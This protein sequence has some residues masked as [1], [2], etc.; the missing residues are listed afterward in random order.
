MK[1]ESFYATRDRFHVIHEVVY[2]DATN[3]ISDFAFQELQ[4]YQ[5]SCKYIEQSSPL[6]ISV[7]A[8]LTINRECLLITNDGESRVFLDIGFIGLAQSICRIMRYIIAV[9]EDA[10]PDSVDELVSQLV[11]CSEAVGIALVVEAA[12]L[13]GDYN[14]SMMF[15]NAIEG[16][17][18]LEPRWGRLFSTKSIDDGDTELL[19]WITRH[20]LLHE[21]NHHLFDHSSA[22]RRQFERFASGAI[23]RANGKITKDTVFYKHL[24]KDEIG[25]YK[26]RGVRI[27]EKNRIELIIKA[28][29]CFLDNIKHSSEDTLEIACDIQVINDHFSYLRE[30][31]P[32]QGWSADVLVHL[33]ARPFLVQYILYCC[34]HIKH[35]ASA[36]VANFS[37]LA[38]SVD[39]KLDLLDRSLPL[40]LSRQ[41]ARP[42]ILYDIVEIN[43]IQFQRD[44][45]LPENI[46][47]LAMALCDRNKNL[48]DGVVADAL[49]AQARF[50]PKA[51]EAGTSG[52]LGNFEK[53]DPATLMPLIQLNLSPFAVPL[54]MQRLW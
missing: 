32:L 21:F 44:F 54:Q 48:L 42:R 53:S 12:Y 51:W 40:G 36:A 37:T 7:D 43:I 25:Q 8:A 47:T 6:A 11:R 28:D 18:A 20:V 15:L 22:A 1:F 34:C 26:A 16:G 24:L 3:W 29:L 9:V 50:V 33:L 46:V 52:S 30:Q 19:V 4:H 17:A 41:A 31:Y 23:L 5:H 14:M 49:L 13:Q 27:N 39:V 45:G 35:S 38:E 2:S 10:E